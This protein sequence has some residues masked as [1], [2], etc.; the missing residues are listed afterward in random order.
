MIRIFPLIICDILLCS[1]LAGLAG[2]ERDQRAPSPP[3]LVRVSEAMPAPDTAI[4][5]FTGKVEAAVSVAASFRVAGKIAERFASAG[6]AVR[7]GQLLARLDDALQQEQVASAQAQVDAAH[8]LLAQTSAKA[9]RAS[10]LATSRAV[11]RNELDDALRQE[12]QAKERLAEAEAQLASAREV[13]GYTRLEA[14]ADGIVARRLAEA[15]ENVQAGQPVVLLALGSGL[16][17]VFELPSSALMAGLAKGQEI[18]VCLADHKEVCARARVHEVA[19][20]AGALRSHQ[21]KARLLDPPKEMLL[22]STVAGSFRHRNPA[23]FAIPAQALAS[24]DGRDAVWIVGRDKTVSLR[25]ITV[26][27]YEEDRIIVASGLEKGD[28]LVAEGGHAL[29]EG[30]RVEAVPPLKRIDESEVGHGK[31]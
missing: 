30:Q 19:P 20:E 25:E 2:C 24:R 23:S 12:R 4:D 6:D 29:L 22:G 7:Q 10:R 16:D 3:R 1:L 15:G 11:S 9:A 18:E 13:L 31:D 27:R 28:V 26:L 8:A 17:A 21:I 5:C 14:S